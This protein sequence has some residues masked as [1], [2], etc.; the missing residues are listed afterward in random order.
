MAIRAFPGSS[1]LRS[2]RAQSLSGGPSIWASWDG[3]E[4]PLRSRH[5]GGMVAFTPPQTHAAGTGHAS[6]LNFFS[7]RRKREIPRPREE[8]DHPESGPRAGTLQNLVRVPHG[9]ANALTL[10]GS[11]GRRI[12]LRL[13]GRFRIPGGS[14]SGV[15]LWIWRS[16][17]CL[18]LLRVASLGPRGF[19]FAGRSPFF[20]RP[21]IG[22]LPFR[23]PGGWLTWSWFLRTGA[24]LGLDGLTLRGARA[25]RPA[26]IVLG[27][28]VGRGRVGLGCRC[29][30]QDQG[31]L[32]GGIPESCPL[33]L[34]VAGQVLG[35]ALLM[36]RELHLRPVLAPP[37]GPGLGVHAPVRPGLLHEGQAELVH[38]EQAL[39]LISGVHADQQGVDRFFS[40]E[41]PQGK[42]PG[43]QQLI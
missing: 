42:D 14:W 32:H 29:L 43:P 16:L 33:G 20:A 19:L 13:R 25:A 11:L 30:G 5:R 41:I 3:Y 12:G 24:G 18:W 35:G 27:L 17:P 4:G 39:P 10:L 38:M 36:A 40:V 7:L 37:V 15:L 9:S 2:P 28:L 26:R 23:L 34:H 21:S 1:S 22:S 31:Q 6:L 8:R